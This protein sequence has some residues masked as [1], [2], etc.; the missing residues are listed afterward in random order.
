[1]PQLINQ[2]WM[3]SMKNIDECPKD[4]LKSRLKLL[5]NET[6][7]HCK[8]LQIKHLLVKGPGIAR[9]LSAGRVL[10]IIYLLIVCFPLV[11][12]NGEIRIV[13]AVEYNLPFKFDF[14][15]YPFDSQLFV[16]PSTIGNNFFKF[17]MFWFHKD[18]FLFQN[19]NMTFGGSNQRLIMVQSL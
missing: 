2:S 9:C 19:G 7:V 12:Q 14:T 15:W 5:A 6:L 8:W 4:R 16:L 17:K 1:L 13:C 10:S 18:I 11:F 3:V